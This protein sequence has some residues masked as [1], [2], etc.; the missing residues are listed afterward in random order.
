METLIYKSSIAIHVLCGILSLAAGLV[1]MIANKG[2]KIHNRAGI[3]FYWSM[4]MIFVTTTIFFILYPTNLKYQ[5]FLG[6]GIVSFYPNW[7][8]KRMLTMKKGVLPKIIDKIGAYLIGL[9]GITMLAYG[10]YLT[11]NPA[12]GF[13]ALNILFF[14]F[15]TVSL[16]NAYGDLKIYLGFVKAEKMHWFFAH[17]GKMMGAY[18]AAIT[19]FCVNIVP[20]FLPENTPFYVFIVTWT[21]PGIIIGILSARILK[22]YK[23]K[24]KIEEKSSVFSRIKPK[25]VNKEPV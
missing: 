16:A 11:Q 15:G 13:D 21:A 9:S 20:R 23:I 22:K 14:V 18:S 5:F 6:I 4:F 12:K 24:F 10:A 17:A 7:S 2:S 8:G 25:L 3:I 1:A 19:A